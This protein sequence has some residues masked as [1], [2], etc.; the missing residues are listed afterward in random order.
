M[1]DRDTHPNSASNV[2]QPTVKGCWSPLPG[3][4]R[5]AAAGAIKEWFDDGSGVARSV[6]LATVGP[7]GLTSGFVGRLAA[8][9]TNSEVLLWSLSKT[10]LS[11][12]LFR[13]IDLGRLTLDAR[14]IDL[15]PDA[16]IDPVATVGQLLS[17]TAG[18]PDYG[19]WPD[20]HE[21]VRQRPDAPWPLEAY[22]ERARS[23]GPI[24]PPGG[25]WAYSNV[26]YLMVR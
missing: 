26:G 6:A 20:Y 23:T 11:A 7:M 1:V 22:L 15:L 8:G 19:S 17:H 12:A 13:L 10:A 21:A 16:P 14:V 4:V 9:A 24:G 25:Q 3:A 18:V 2:S 5:T